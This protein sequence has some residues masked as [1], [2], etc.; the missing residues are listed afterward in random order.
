[1]GNFFFTYMLEYK[2]KEIMEFWSEV[3][4][5]LLDGSFSPD[6]YT[7]KFTENTRHRKYI[8]LQAER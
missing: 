2:A 5:N 8:R 7:K 4:Q 6:T 3:M 1:M